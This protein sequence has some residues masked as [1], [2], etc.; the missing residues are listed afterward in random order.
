MSEASSQTPIINYAMNKAQS[1][2]SVKI[3]LGL[4]LNIA[5]ENNVPG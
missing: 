4:Y 5:D 1:L 2:S 3:L